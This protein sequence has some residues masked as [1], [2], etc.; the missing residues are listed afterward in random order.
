MGRG[1]RPLVV[2][3]AIAAATFV[4]AETHPFSPSTTPTSTTVGDAARGAAIFESTC[5]GCH[6]PQGSGGGVG[7]TLA[8]AGLDAG[9]VSAT[10]EQG[11]GA[12]P[13]GLVSGQDEADVV[14]Y[15]VSISSAGG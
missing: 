1:W 14:A 9:T 15:V 12:M 13:A 10:V 5:S 3:G 8:G 6:G 2:G 11:R 7:P 4:L